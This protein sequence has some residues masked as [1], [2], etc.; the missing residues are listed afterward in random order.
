M[1][2]ALM[3]ER[4]ETT[5]GATGAGEVTKRRRGPFGSYSNILTYVGV[6][7][8]AAGFGL[9]AFGWGKVAGLG[10]VA[11]QMPYLVSAGITG[12]A[13]V[14]VGVLLVNVAAKRQGEEDLAR[15]VER[16]SAILTDLD[17]SLRRPDEHA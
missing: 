3:Q 14:I 4:P 10:D 16:L 6:V 15:Q 7:V 8:I 5:P 12:L 1:T 2:E 17:R 11:S 13:L 9:I